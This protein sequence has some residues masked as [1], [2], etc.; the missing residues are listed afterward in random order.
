MNLS[1]QFF[2][3]KKYLLNFLVLFLISCN[4]NK[5]HHII[6]DNPKSEDLKVKV[7]QKEYEIPAFGTI[8]I[9]LKSGEY[10]VEAIINDS[11][12]FSER[13]NVNTSGLLNIFK[14]T[15]V[16]WTD[17]Y[18]INQKAN[19]KKLKQKDFY[20][21]EKLY[22]NVDFII[23]DDS[24]FISKVWDFNINEAWEES[25]NYYFLNSELKSKIYRI[26][27]LEK[28][29]GYGPLPDFTEYTIQELKNRVKT[30]ESKKIYE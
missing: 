29:F 28:E 16:L 8:E 18:K 24:I 3:D 23:Y 9:N 12:F 30:L 15:Y 13:I 7:N 21:N 2:R 19:T 6:I 27:D 4:I 10:K 5:T 1:I 22:E 14:E 25:L 17:L 11:C 20:I 26:N